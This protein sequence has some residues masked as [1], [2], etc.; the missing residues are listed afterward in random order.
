[1]TAER[2]GGMGWVSL[3]VEMRHSAGRCGMGCGFVS[4]SASVSAG[5]LSRFLL[6]SRSVVTPTITSPPFPSMAVCPRARRFYTSH[7]AHRRTPA[8]PDFA[9]PYTHQVAAGYVLHVGEVAGGEVKVGDA[10]TVRVDYERRGLIKPNHTFTHVLNYALKWVTRVSVWKGA[11]ARRGGCDWGR[12]T[13]GRLGSVA[14]FVMPGDVDP[15]GTASGK[16]ASVLWLNGVTRTKPNVVMA[17]SAAT[18]QT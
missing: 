11:G 15:A 13:G 12:G 5:R 16:G 10:V 3:R 2:P 14:V 18:Y 8:V 7:L 1:M 9:L 6:L 4:S 17:T